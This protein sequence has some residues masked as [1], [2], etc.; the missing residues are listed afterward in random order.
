MSWT[1]GQTRTYAYNGRDSAVFEELDPGDYTI[2][3]H[4]AKPG[5]FGGEGGFIEATYSTTTPQTL[6]IYVGSDADGRDG[7]WGLFRG[8]NADTFDSGG[9]GGSTEVHLSEVSPYQDSVLVVADAGGGGA[10]LTSGANGGGGARCGTAN[11]ETCDAGCPANVSGSG[12]YGGAVANTGGPGGQNAYNGATIV[13]QNQGG[14]KHPDGTLNGYVEITLD[15]AL[16]K[17]ISGIVEEGSTSIS[18]ATIEAVN[19]STTNTY[20]TTTDSSGNWSMSVPAGTYHVVARYEDANGK[21]RT[22]SKPYISVN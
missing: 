16:S 3:V 2:K 21:K 5:S 20:T 1:Q 8:G 6:E 13:T 7:G 10:S 22:L 15:N 14:S 11:N 19:H 4:G 12:G 18:G 9:G 17:T